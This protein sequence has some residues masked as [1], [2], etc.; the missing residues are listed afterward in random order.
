MNVLN[1]NITSDDR[2]VIVQ[3]T[4]GRVNAEGE[5]TTRNVLV[6][7]YRDLPM[8]LKAI[9]DNFIMDNDESSPVITE[10]DDMVNAYQTLEENFREF[11]DKEF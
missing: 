6:G 7:Y 4:V 5:K 11:I 3:K 10:I 9:K 8:A 2:N 1:Y